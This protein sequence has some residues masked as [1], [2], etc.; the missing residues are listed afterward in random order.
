MDYT[1]WTVWAK[2]N[3]QQLSVAAESLSTLL[4]D[5]NTSLWLQNLTPSQ[6]QQI[7]SLIAAIQALHSALTPEIKQILGIV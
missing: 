6:Q 2:E 7:K 5:Q 3:A 4:Q 1:Q